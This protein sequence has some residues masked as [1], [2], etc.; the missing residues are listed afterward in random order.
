MVCDLA[1]SDVEECDDVDVS[2]VCND[3]QVETL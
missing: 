2:A 3:A 1:D